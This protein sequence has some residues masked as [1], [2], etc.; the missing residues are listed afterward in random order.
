MRSGLVRANLA[1]WP[2]IKPPGGRPSGGLGMAQRVGAT[3]AFG[4]PG[5][6]AGGSRHDGCVP[7]SAWLSLI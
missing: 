4:G 1:H 2:A 3:L 5:R 6:F 7:L